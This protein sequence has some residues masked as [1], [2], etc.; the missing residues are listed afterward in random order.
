MNTNR[1]IL[2]GASLIVGLALSATASFASEE[3]AE[4]AQ[5]LDH[6]KITLGQAVAIAEAYEHGKAFKAEAE[7]DRGGWVFDVEVVGKEGIR[8]VVVSATDGHVVR[9]E[10]DEQDSDD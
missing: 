8:E 5:S 1:Q 7:H 2:C 9:V 3:E 10:T 6:L 4:V